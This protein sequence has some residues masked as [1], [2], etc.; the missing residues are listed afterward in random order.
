M[1]EQL[2]IPDDVALLMAGIAV[3]RDVQLAAGEV[4]KRTPHLGTAFVTLG[5]ALAMTRQ[6]GIGEDDEVIYRNLINLLAEG[7]V[8]ATRLRAANPDLRLAA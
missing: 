4:V 8:V 3:R 1:D 6:T 2:R 5:A 7:E